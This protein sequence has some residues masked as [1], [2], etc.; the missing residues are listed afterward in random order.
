MGLRNTSVQWGSV[1]RSLHWLVAIGIAALIWLGLAQSELPRGDEKTQIRMIH[2][3][4]ALVVFVLM[5]MRIVWRGMNETPA[6]PPGNP[7]WQA[8]VASLVHWGLYIA[9]FVQLV[10]GAMTVATTG[11]GLPFFGLFQVPLPVAESRDAHEFWEDIHEPFWWVVA[12]LV[13]I[14]VLGALYNHFVARN[15]V[16]RR[17]TTGTG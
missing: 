3:S 9:I 14:H 10:S 8:L 6:H 17:M 13:G 12:V 15:D 2:A 7:A 5:T 11:T 4:I 1:A 16:L